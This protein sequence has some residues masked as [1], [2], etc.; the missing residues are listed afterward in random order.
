MTAPTFDSKS[1]YVR[2]AALVSLAALGLTACGGDSDGDIS[3]AEN[4]GSSAEELDTVRVATS[5]SN[6]FIFMPVQAMDRLGTFDEVGLDVE[7][8]EATTPTINQVITGGEADI[9]L[10]GGNSIVAGIEQ[11]VEMTLVASSMS[12][13]DQR[14]IAH[15][16]IES[17]EDLEGG[18]LGISGAG[19]PGHYA[20]EKLAE[21]MAWEEGS[22]YTLTSVGDLQ[23][24]T[25]ALTT[26]TIDVFAWNSQTAFQMEESGDAVVLGEASEYVGEVVLQAFGVTDDFIEENP[27]E[28]Q[29]FF[30]AYFDM[31]QQLQDDPQLF[32]D[33][34]V[35]EWD[36]EQAVAQRLAEEGPLENISS[37]GAITEAELEGLIESAEF[38][39]EGA[40]I[41]DANYVY[42]QDLD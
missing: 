9:A 30:E 17:V 39:L 8:I 11:G 24:L 6:S 23:G 19:A 34:L 33:I 4:G 12:D 35:E 21:A 14:L 40:E 41:E 37:D 5:V 22:D 1:P 29:I 7:L 13:W 27:E 36:V 32:I 18:N 15:P 2:A 26:G 25:A 42:W 38:T 31:V 28:I 10:A 20:V 3:A 16:E